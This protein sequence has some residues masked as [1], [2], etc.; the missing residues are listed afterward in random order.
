MAT[1][2]P[3]V[4]GADGR[5]QELQAGDSLSVAGGPTTLTQTADATLLIGATVYNSAADHV[6]NARSN[7]SPQTFAVGMAQ[8]AIASLATGLIQYDGVLTLTTAQWDAIAGTT[9]GLTFGT[10]YYLDPTTA[11]KITATRPTTVG[12]YVVIVG[13]AQ[14]ATELLLIMSQAA[15]L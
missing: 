4:L 6:N 13:M 8:A 5:V 2:I 7:G 3:L 11:G 14:S 12:Q 1:R 15:L 10:L 9:G